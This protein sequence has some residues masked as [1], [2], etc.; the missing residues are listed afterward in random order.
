M[1]PFRLKMCFICLCTSLTLEWVNAFNLFLV[2]RYI[3]MKYNG[4]TI[5]VT[6]YEYLAELWPLFD[7]KCASFLQ[8]ITERPMDRFSIFLF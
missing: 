2:H 6:T 3:V 4:P 1:A 7:L 5:F 8:M